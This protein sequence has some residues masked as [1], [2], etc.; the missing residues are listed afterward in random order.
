MQNERKPDEVQQKKHSWHSPE[1]RKISVK[2]NTQQGVGLVND[3]DGFEFT[4][5]TVL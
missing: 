2:R 5:K 1:L 4:S 3:A